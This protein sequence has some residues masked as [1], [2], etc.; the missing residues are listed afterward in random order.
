MTARKLAEWGWF[1]LWLLLTVV[2]LWARPAI[3]IDETRYLSVAWEMW[4]N[5]QFLV[6]HSNGLPYSHK[7]PLLFWL[8]NCGWWLMGVQEWS[9]RLTAPLC[10]LA[11]I[12]LSR[13]LAGTL[14]SQLPEVRQATLFILC[15]M[16]FWAI[17]ASLTMFDT[18]LT[19][20]ALV[21]YLIVYHAATGQS[22]LWWLRLGVTIGIGILAKGPIILVYVIPVALLAPWWSDRLSLPKWKWYS[23][24]VASLVVA[25]LVALAWALP[26]AM[27]GGEEYGQAILF[28]QTAGRMVK[29]FAH[30]RPFYWYL[31]LLPLLLFPWSCWLPVWR[32]VLRSAIHGN[33]RFLLSI[34]LPGLVILSLIS[35]KQIHYLLPLLPIVAILLARGSV[36]MAEDKRVDRILLFSIFGLVSLVIGTLP[37]LPLRG[38]DAIIL[39]QLPFWIGVCPLPAGGTL[40]LFRKQHGWITVPK[41]TLAA[42]LLLVALHLAA[43]RP[44]QTTYGLADIPRALSAIEQ[45]DQQIAVYPQSL[46]DQLQFA[47][48]LTAPV[49]PLSSLEDVFTQATTAPDSYTLFHVKRYTLPALPERAVTTPYKKGWLLLL[50]SSEF[51]RDSEFMKNLLASER[52]G[53]KG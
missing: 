32:G 4:N 8:I 19:C 11:A 38:S 36:N 25:C 6:P 7:P 9:A 12:F 24:T 22:T 46:D 39:K 1:P 30:Q 29:S 14:F 17:Y 37:F 34:L 13:R 33:N 47:A 40:L 35:G 18:L 49:I 51:A 31:A 21:A 43:A 26:A 5:G 42:T 50:P 45:Q 23:A 2:A 3:P 44:L 10:G 20:I 53:K 41:I 48:R 52:G 15:G 16:V 28:G 27:A